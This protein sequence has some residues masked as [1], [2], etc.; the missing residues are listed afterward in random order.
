ATPGL[1]STDEV[2]GLEP[3]SA[4]SVRG[5]PP[6]FVPPVAHTSAPAAPVT[7]VGSQRKK[8]TV[9]G[10]LPPTA[11]PVT[12]ALSKSIVP[13]ATGLVSPV[14][15]LSDG[16]VTVVVGIVRTMKHSS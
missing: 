16:V 11:V 1:D 15:L 2:G 6:R 3:A 12:T 4:T 13:R 8:S 9:P 7:C 14:P 10:G 5:L